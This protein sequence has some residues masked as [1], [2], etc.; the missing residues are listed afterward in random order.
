MAVEIKNHSDG[1]TAGVTKEKQLKTRAES[2]ELQH[3]VAWVNEDVYQCQA[4]DTSVTATTDQVL[5]IKN[6]SSTKKCVISYIRMQ[7]VTDIAATAEV[8]EYFDVIVGD[9]VASGGSAAV[10]TN[11]NLSSGKVAEVTATL[12]DP[13]MDGVGTLID[14]IYNPSSGYEHRYTKHGSLILGLNDTIHVAFTSG[15]S[16]GHVKVRFTFMMMDNDR[17]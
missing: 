9:T 11:T 17:D 1:T 12:G 2:H 15:A 5:H 13:T 14:R 4:I 16:A 10:V 6:T 3:H 8:T 7:A